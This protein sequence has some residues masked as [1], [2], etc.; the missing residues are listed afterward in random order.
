MQPHFYLDAVSSLLGAAEEIRMVIDG[1][2]GSWRGSSH[3]LR[4]APGEEG[5]PQKVPRS[6]LDRAGSHSEPGRL[7]AAPPQPTPHH[8]RER[9]DRTHVPT[10]SMHSWAWF[11][12]FFLSFLAAPL[13]IWDLSS[14]TRD[15]T[16]APCIGSGES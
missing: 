6:P 13:G 3:L 9:P 2:A 15:R 14:L 4:D 16:H 1:L 8:T 10:L 11:L 12:S 5:T 7:A